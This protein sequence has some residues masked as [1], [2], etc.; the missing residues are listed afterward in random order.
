MG[1][2]LHEAM[3]LAAHIGLHRESRLGK[4]A[5][6]AQ[7]PNLRP[8]KPLCLNAFCPLLHSIH[9]LLLVNRPQKHFLERSRST[10]PRFSPFTFTHLMLFVFSHSMALSFAFTKISA[11]NTQASFSFIF[12][13]AAEESLPL[14]SSPSPS[15]RHRHASSP[16]LSQKFVHILPKMHNSASQ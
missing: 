10:G 7:C 2:W 15:A 11:S 6:L 5:L 16:V 9:H 8:S 13:N 3:A 14:G 1:L 4:P 12:S